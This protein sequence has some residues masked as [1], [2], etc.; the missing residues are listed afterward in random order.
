MDAMAFYAADR[1]PYNI[2]G[3]TDGLDGVSRI[4]AVYPHCGFGSAANDGFS[5]DRSITTLL[6]VAGMDESVSSKR[7]RAWYDRQEN[8]DVLLSVFENAQHTFDIPAPHNR[9]PAR[10]SEEYLQQAMQEVR[11]LLR[12]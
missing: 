8:A 10:F 5:W 12:F 3:T 2:T 11:A 9:N 7:C 4:V 6:Q 1:N